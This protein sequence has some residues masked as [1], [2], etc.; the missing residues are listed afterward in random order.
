MLDSILLFNR[1]N[2]LEIQ[3]TAGLGIIQ[4]NTPEIQSP[5]ELD[6]GNIHFILSKSSLD[7]HFVWE[8]TKE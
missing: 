8:Y 2:T 3:T 1:V 5:R 7:L 4:L 6:P